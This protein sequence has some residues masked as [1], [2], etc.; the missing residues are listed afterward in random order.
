[1][2][3]SQCYTLGEISLGGSGGMAGA[4]AGVRGHVEITNCYTRGDITGLENTGGICGRSAGIDKGI[5][6]ISNVYASG[7]IDATGAGTA[8]Q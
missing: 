6:V 7:N 5:V 1:M 8:L 3:I 4:A 2:K